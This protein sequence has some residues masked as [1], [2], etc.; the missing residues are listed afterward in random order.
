MS[1][2][3][4]NCGNLLAAE[5]GATIYFRCTTC[6]YRFLFD[7]KIVYDTPL[8]R[9]EVDA[10]LGEEQWKNA[11]KTAGLAVATDTQRTARNAAGRRRTSCRFKFARRTSR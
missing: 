7:R 5:M 11:Q 3:C 2:F 6:P 10:V 4:P 1:Y 8:Q 9:K